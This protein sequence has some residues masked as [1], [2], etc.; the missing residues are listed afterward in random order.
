MSVVGLRGRYNERDDFLITTVPPV[1]E[2]GTSTS[3]EFFFPHFADGDGYTTQFILF[4]GLAGQTTSGTMRF[5]NTSGE[6]ISLP[7]Q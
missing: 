6:A 4:A 7:V 2:S 3:A 1:D 5:S